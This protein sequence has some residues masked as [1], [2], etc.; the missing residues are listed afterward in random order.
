MRKLL[1]LAQ[2]AVVLG[3]SPS[4]LKHQARKGH[5]V[6]LLVGKSYVVTADE[7]ERYRREHLGR[8]GRPLG[9][10]NKHR[11]SAA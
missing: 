10:K 1:S 9:A 6:A 11:R 2:A 8:H 3:L 4:T 5:L 7:V